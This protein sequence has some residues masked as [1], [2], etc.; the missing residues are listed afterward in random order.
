[1]SLIEA[2][3]KQSDFFRLIDQAYGLIEKRNVM[4][5]LSKVLIGFKKDQFHLQATDQDNSIQCQAPAQVKGEGEMVVDAQNLFEILKELEDKPISIREQKKKKIRITQGFCVFNLLSLNVEDFPSFPPFQMKESFSMKASSLKDLLEKT[6]YCS[7]KDE[8]RYHLTG[9]YF[10]TVKNSSN[11]FQFRFV[12]TDGHRLGLAE[13]DCEKLFLKEQ[14]G[15][16]LSRKGVHEVKKMISNNAK[17]E[18]EVA[19]EKPRILF[20]QSQTILSVKLVDGTYPNYESF[21]PKKSVSS[22]T[23]EKESFQQALKRV[24]LLSSSRFKGVT[25]EIEKNRMEMKAEHPDLGSAHDEVEIV[26][27][28]GSD[29]TVRFNARYILEALLT[30]DEEQVV[31]E[32]GGSEFPCLIKSVPNKKSQKGKNFCVVMPMKI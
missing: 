30:L 8:T 18:I 26:K 24:S 1:M 16:I 14:G 5:I 29:L 23:L 32:F 25:F 21:I 17:D 6:S 19:I 31:L 15:V 7:S 3:V 22:V 4:P 27:K 2:Q 13:L 9:V 20:R 11:Q 10:D 28:K 12:A